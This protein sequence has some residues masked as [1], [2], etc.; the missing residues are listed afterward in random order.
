MPT[1]LSTDRFLLLLGLESYLA[2]LDKE[3]SSRLGCQQ[4]SVRLRFVLCVLAQ[5]SLH[6]VP[7]VDSARGI[8]E[9]YHKIRGMADSNM[10]SQIIEE[11]KRAKTGSRDQMK[12]FLMPG[13]RSRIEAFQEDFKISDDPFYLLKAAERLVRSISICLS[14][15]TRLKDL[16]SLESSPLAPENSS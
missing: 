12:L 10:G 7:T 2:S 15:R 9:T 5:C 3:I 13:S 14:S 4:K 8:S 11:L 1:Y 16:K 6:G